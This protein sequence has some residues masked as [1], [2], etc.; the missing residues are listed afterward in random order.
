MHQDEI[1]QA[2]KHTIKY[3]SLRKLEEGCSNNGG[4]T[5]LG[6][7]FTFFTYELS[8]GDFTITLI[9]RSK[10]HSCTESFCSLTIGGITIWWRAPLEQNTPL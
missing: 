7:L 2:R 5:C 3:F 1:A 4:G 10:I 8:P 9:K 6:G